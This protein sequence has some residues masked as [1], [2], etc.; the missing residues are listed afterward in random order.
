MVPYGDKLRRQ[1]ID[2]IYSSA[3]FS[4]VINTLA[5]TVVLIVYWPT[6]QGGVTTWFALVVAVMFYRLLA[7]LYYKMHQED[8]GVKR[9]WL[10]LLIGMLMSATVWVSALWYFLGRQDIAL[11]FLMAFVMG[12]LASGAVTTLS[13]DRI[14]AVT[15]IT[16]ILGGTVLWLFYG[17]EPVEI[18]MGVL[19]LAYLAFLI[20]SSGRINKT[21]VDALTLRKKNIEAIRALRAHKA[22]MDLIFDNVP[23]GIFFYDK[24]F[25]IVNVNQYFVDIFKSDRDRL[26]GLNLEELVDK[27]IAQSIR[28]PIDYNGLEEGSYEGRYHTTTSD[29]DVDIRVKTTALKDSRNRLVGA[30]GIVE[31]IAMELDNK[32]KI[33]SFAQFYI[34]N[35]NPVFRIECP[36]RKVLLENGPAMKIRFSVEASA[37]KRWE[38]FLRKVCDGGS[39]SVEL[40]DGD[41][42]Y[43]FD[44]AATDDGHMNLYGRDVTKERIARERADYL[45]YY[46]ELTGLPRRKLLFE[47][48]KIAMMRAERNGTYNA[49]LFLD[50]D[51]FKQINDSMGHDIGDYLLK[52]LSKRLSSLMR[53]GDI[54]ARLG[55]DE[56]VI[57]L[58]DL[59]GDSEEAA[60]KSE[61]VAR[62]IRKEVAKP[63]LIK[64]RKLH[65]SVSIGVTLFNHGKDFFTLL[66]EAD[67]AMYEAKAAGRNCVKLFDA[68][69]EKLTVDK[70]EM[71]QDLHN[72]IEKGQL[73]LLYH[74]QI[75]ISSGRCVGA[76]A[77][78]RWEHPKRGPVSPEVF[79]PLAEESGVIHE[80]GQ[81]VLKTVAKDCSDLHLDYIAVNVSIKEFVRSD[82]IDVIRGM[83][84]RGEIDPSRIELEMTESVFVGSY[85]ETNEK[86][87]E[88]KEMGFRFSIDDFGTGYSSLSY[89]KNLSIKTLKI[90]RGFVQDIGISPNDEVLTRTIID[91]ASHFGMKTVAE[92]VENETQLAFLKKFGCDLAQGYYFSKPMSI[93]SFVEWLAECKK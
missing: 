51:N 4:I 3:P 78:L 26:I 22:E 71:M 8:I 55:G 66:K 15:Y 35:P 87:Q 53:T 33:E 19:V 70:T 30:I 74:P 56:F 61:I 65:F 34:R 62:K 37:K 77:L 28:A 49:L 60:M 5:A 25:K 14:I 68:K 81:W 24:E 73:K 42:I 84:D 36:S 76:E 11:D 45:A 32:R 21:I 90:D 58:A 52:Q 38:H 91:I 20:L 83:A 40:R 93:E 57:L 12:G 79:I 13:S 85:A 64:G 46:D 82:F 31:D 17:G 9:A 67:V 2:M 72:A 47:H 75:E 44:V 16:I 63:F 59:E 18:M 7:Y 86:L 50:L 89:L 48:I 88:L 39:R 41:T 54:V 23:V 92:G 27:R 43:Q 1:M 69:L 10:L 80:L 29:I 6:S